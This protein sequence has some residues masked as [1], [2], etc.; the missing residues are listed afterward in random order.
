[1]QY[2]VSITQSLN[3]WEL[4]TG[5]LAL[6]CPSLLRLPSGGRQGG[7]ATE[8]PRGTSCGER[9]DAFDLAGAQEA[10]CCRGAFCMRF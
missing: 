6:H 9:F 4:E 5:L 8:P 7:A 1:M 2:P 10:F 3:P